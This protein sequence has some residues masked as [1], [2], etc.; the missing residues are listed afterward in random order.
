MYIFFF[1]REPRV[2]FENRSYAR[3]EG[4]TRVNRGNFRG[5]Q[6]TGF[7]GRGRG[8][9]F[10]RYEVYHDEFGERRHR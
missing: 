4:Q 5:N 10:P 7:P 3:Y 9:N 6:R 8:Q 2:G 1:L